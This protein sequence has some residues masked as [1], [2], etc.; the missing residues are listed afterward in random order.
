M[1]QVL[2][3]LFWLASGV[4]GVWLIWIVFQSFWDDR[5]ALAAGMLRRRKGYLVQI[6]DDAIDV[7]FKNE[8]QGTFRKSEITRTEY[9]RDNCFDSP[10]GLCGAI[11]LYC[12]S[13]CVAHVPESAKNFSELLL[14]VGTH[15]NHKLIE[16]KLCH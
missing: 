2:S 1:I 6:Q 8:K 13:T 9:I 5:M 10:T 7:L 14:W 15:A 11:K 4:G 16:V 3:I 12:H